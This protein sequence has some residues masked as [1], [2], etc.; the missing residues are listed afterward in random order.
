M[1]KFIGI[2]PTGRKLTILRSKIRS[3]FSS[4]DMQMKKLGRIL[5]H[6]YRINYFVVI[7]ERYS[8]RQSSTWSSI[9][10]AF[11]RTCTLKGFLLRDNGGFKGLFS[12]VYHIKL[13]KRKKNGRSRK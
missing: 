7:D 11:D 4:G 1:D 2:R 10:V 8:P 12:R 3:L 9:S 13:Y 6:Q 5:C